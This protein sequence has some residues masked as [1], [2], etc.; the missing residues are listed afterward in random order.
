MRGTET[1]QDLQSDDREEGIDIRL[2]DIF[3]F[4]R[5]N[6]LRMLIAGAVG[7]VIAAVY[8]YTLPNQY[9]SQVT[10][11]PELQNRAPGGNLGGLSSL[12]GL[13]GVELGSLSGGIEAIRP[14]LYPNVLQSIPFGLHL[15]QQPVYSSNARKT[16]PLADFLKEE[17]RN[18]SLIS[19]MMANDEAAEAPVPL[20][21]KNTSRAI[22]VT[23]DQEGLISVLNKQVGATY[24]K[25]TGM[26]SIQ[27]TLSDPVV[28]AT[29]ARLSLEYLTNYV[30]SYRTGKSRLQ[31]DFLSQRVSEA[32]QRYQSAEYALESWRDRNRSLF[33]NVAKLEEQR[34][35][36]DFLLTQSVYNDLS[37][38]LE[39]AKIKVQEEAP[40]FKTLEPP[41]VPLHK[42]GPKRMVM[43]VIGA[44]LGGII[45]LALSLGSVFRQ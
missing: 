18:A 10:V 42:S 15:I 33:T 6:R 8:A 29:V 11:M 24:D 41:R 26:L 32:R 7:A 40:V 16:L 34:L 31:A 43:V 38:Q 37:K 28:A 44:V 1:I 4:L 25:K 17:A 20:D 36:A 39:Q 22:V 2:T 21:P 14:D 13:A 35:Q 9:T 3:R 23:P 30:T 12:A 19:R 5:R 45:G 27:A